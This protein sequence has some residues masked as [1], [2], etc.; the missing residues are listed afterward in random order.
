MRLG[1]VLSVSV[2]VAAVT[3]LAAGC[4]PKEGKSCRQEGTE[5]CVDPKN[6]LVCHGA[7][8]E[9]MLCR[10][11]SG[12]RKV[13]SEAECDQSVAE[14]G[15]VCNLAD[16]VVCGS[17]KKSMLECKQN[18]WTRAS[19]CL[20]QN[21]CVLV[22]KTV[23]CDNTI[24]ELGDACTHPEDYACSPD[25]KVELVCKGGKYTVS[26]TCRG[27]KGCSLVA[28]QI[29]C[30]DTRAVLNDACGKDQT[31]TCD[32]EGKSILVCRSG[33]YVVDEAC[34]GKLNCRVLGTKVGCF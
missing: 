14:P 27:P 22:G 8:W 24:A 13:G 4:K 2:A 26:A 5:S 29:S 34:K 1:N 17:D 33:H 20:G 3:V 31:Y 16:D 19:N 15:D 12:C 32:M 11:A 10:G 23:K 28:K 30:D 21:G 6:A 7:V 18:H 9:P 25:K